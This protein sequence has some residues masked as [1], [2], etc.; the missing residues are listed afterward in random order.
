MR[1]FCVVHPVCKKVHW[2]CPLRS[3]SISH[4]SVLHSK[5]TY[6]SIMPIMRLFPNNVTVIKAR[7]AKCSRHKTICEQ[8]SNGSNPVTAVAN[9]LVRILSHAQIYLVRNEARIRKR[10]HAARTM[11]PSKE[12]RTAKQSAISI[13]RCAAFTAHSTQGVWTISGLQI[14]DRPLFFWRRV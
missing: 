11:G 2:F 6:L 7:A 12:R 8:A 9:E 10:S 14:R 5:I 13:S 4:Y 3:G 1:L